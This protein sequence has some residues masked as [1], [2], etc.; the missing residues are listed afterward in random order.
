MVWS[1]Y[2]G[3]VSTCPHVYICRY[4][5]TLGMA[6]HSWDAQ[7]TVVSAV[8]LG[9]FREVLTET[10]TS[11]RKKKTWFPGVVPF[12]QSIDYKFWW[13]LMIKSPL[14]PIKSLL[15]TGNSSMFSF[16]KIE[17]PRTF[18][19]RAGRPPPSPTAFISD[20]R[21]QWGNVQYFWNLLYPFGNTRWLQ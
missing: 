11:T 9:C 17:C 4:T 16:Q 1:N 13:L 8:S 3:H 18:H 15:L 7:V 10:P 5:Y 12:N 20:S 19:L 6:F 2:I 14:K 21:S